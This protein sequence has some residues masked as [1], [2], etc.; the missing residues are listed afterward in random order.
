M[1]I[2]Y[3]YSYIYI[4]IY[5]HFKINQTKVNLVNIP[6]FLFCYKYRSL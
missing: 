1:P 3:L 5:I 4:Y 6:Y 2:K